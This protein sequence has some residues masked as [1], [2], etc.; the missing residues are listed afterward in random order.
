M[1]L[2]FVL[3]CV[4]AVD[5]QKAEIGPERTFVVVS[6]IVVAV[7][8]LLK[9]MDH[10]DIVFVCTVPIIHIDGFV[11]VEQELIAR[12]PMIVHISPD[13]GIAKGLVGN[14]LKEQAG[15][16]LVG[17]FGRV[18]IV[19]HQ[20]TLRNIH[21]RE[22]A[23]TFSGR[24]LDLDG[25]CIPVVV[26]FDCGVSAAIIAILVIRYTHC[27]V[28]FVPSIRQAAAAAAAAGVGY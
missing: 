12:A 13:E 19:P 22:N 24:S 20:G 28:G 11:E 18:A 3:L 16:A 21:P 15:G 1:L 25:H 2:R 23:P 26:D 10:V 4:V 14:T 17:E 6:S 8:F 7:Y 27:F 9:I 5:P